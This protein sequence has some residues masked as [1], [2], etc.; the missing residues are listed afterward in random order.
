MKDG[1]TITSLAL[2]Y[3]TSPPTLITVHLSTCIRYYSLPSSDSVSLQAQTLTYVRQVH[4]A[5]SAPILVSAVSS[6]STLLATGSSDGVVK[7]WDLEGSYVTHAFRG[8]GGPVSA[9]RFNVSADSSKLELFTGSTDSRVRIF[10]LRDPSARGGSAKPRAVL[11]GHVS[12]VRGID[13]GG[14]GRWA[15]TGGR[16]KVVLVWDLLAGESGIARTPGKGKENGPRLVQTIITQEQVE[17]VGLLP[18]T[19]HESSLMCY[20]A[21]DR[22]LVRIWDVMKGEEMARM[23]GVEGVDEVEADEDEQRG[24]LQ[25]L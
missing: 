15:V 20:T 13:I 5:H 2:A 18:R 22:G 7:V 14:D 24:V 1:T 6:D 17:A 4:K 16:D 19:D 8:H 11:E 23:K 25:V 10:N 9:L 21:G 12:V 3:H